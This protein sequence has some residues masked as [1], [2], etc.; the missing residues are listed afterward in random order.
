MQAK[1]TSFKK[2]Q[3]KQNKLSFKIQPSASF[4]GQFAMASLKQVL[5]SI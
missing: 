5:I 1:K 4:K 3:N 2:I